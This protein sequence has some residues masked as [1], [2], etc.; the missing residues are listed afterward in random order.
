MAGSVRAAAARRSEPRFCS[1]SNLKFAFDDA[2]ADRRG[3]PVADEIL[4]GERV[5]WCQNV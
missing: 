1:V 2:R 5:G 3:A 4:L